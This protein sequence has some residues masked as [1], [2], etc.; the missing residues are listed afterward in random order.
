MFCYISFWGL[1]S[2]QMPKDD[3]EKLS[4]G[5]TML[6]T[7]M[8]IP[9]PRS[10]FRLVVREWYKGG[11]ARSLTSI[12]V[13]EGVVD[14]SS[15]DA[16]RTS[17]REN[18]FR[19]LLKNIVSR[20]ET[21]VFFQYAHSSSF[22]KRFLRSSLK[23]MLRCF[24][25]YSCVDHEKLNDLGPFRMGVVMSERANVSLGTFLDLQAAFYNISNNRDCL[26]DSDE[27][28]GDSIALPFSQPISPD[29]DCG[30]VNSVE[31]RGS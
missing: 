31:T 24:K 18:F 9:M 19:V 28:E 29:V 2:L 1:W 17:I 20:S 12:V 13:S 5:A 14:N 8:I 16:Y 22:S 4:D 6:R 11:Q 27:E 30:N 26:L 7:C 21:D 15:P 25:S 3:L 10:E 23:E